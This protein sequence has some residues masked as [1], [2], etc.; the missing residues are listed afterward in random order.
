[1]SNLR[2]RRVLE[3]ETLDKLFLEISQFTKAK[4]KRETELAELL[5]HAEILQHPGNGELAP[6]VSV[7]FKSV[8]DAEA[9]YQQLAGCVYGRKT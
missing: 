4:T 8:D 3:T 6:T 2:R 7:L 1:M 9:F 5:Q